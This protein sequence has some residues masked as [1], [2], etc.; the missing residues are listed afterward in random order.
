MTDDARV[1]ETH[2]LVMQFPRQQGWKSFFKREPGKLALSG[3]TLSIPKG[4]IFGLLGPNGAGKTTLVKI[5]STLTIPT[6]GKAYV[7]GLD[8]VKDSL[9]VRGR[10][11][12]VYGDER[13]FYWRLSA[14]DNLLFYAALYGIPPTR[15][16]ERAWELLELVGLKHAAHTR[17]HHYSSGMKQRASIARG[18]I[19][20][21]DIL[22]M[23][24]PTR[25]LD[26]MAA[27]EVR[28]LVKDRVVNES[29]TVLIATN[30]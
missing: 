25:T 6:G 17:M 9:G 28:R 8:V 14:L 29:R 21:P 24:E 7:N 5:L 3:V 2:D 15:A 23:D 4:E 27:L 13:T 20:D 12:V 19:N 16:R 10:I 11:G 1:I 18:L 26:P 22:I 30:I